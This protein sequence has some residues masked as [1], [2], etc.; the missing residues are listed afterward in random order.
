MIEWGINALNHGS[1]LAVINNGKL[2]SNQS[3]FNDELDQSAIFE[4]LHQDNY[5]QDNIVEYLI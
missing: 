1:S 2:I 4:A 3:S 5:V